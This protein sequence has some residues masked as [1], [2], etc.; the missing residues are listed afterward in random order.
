[1]SSTGESRDTTYTQIS[2]AYFKRL[3][4]PLTITLLLIAGLCVIVL[5]PPG[6]PYSTMGFSG[7]GGVGFM[8]RFQ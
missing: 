5:A 2:D 8:R 1:M 4:V 6:T 3:I 7:G